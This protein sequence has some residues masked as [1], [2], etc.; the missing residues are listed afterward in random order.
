MNE[1]L[2]LFEE[3]VNAPENGAET[4]CENDYLVKGVRIEDLA[5]EKMKNRSVR[6]F[7]KGYSDIFNVRVDPSQKGYRIALGINA[8]KRKLGKMIS[9]AGTK[10]NFL[11]ETLPEIQKLLGCYADDIQLVT[12]EMTGHNEIGYG[13]CSQSWQL[14]SMKISSMAGGKE[15]ATYVPVGRKGKREGFWFYNSNRNEV[16]Y[17]GD[18]SDLLAPVIFLNMLQEAIRGQCG[19][20]GS[21]VKRLLEDKLEGLFSWN[22][23]VGELTLEEEFR[24]LLEEKGYQLDLDQM[25]YIRVPGGRLT[26]TDEV[27]GDGQ[28]RLRWLYCLYKCIRS[29]ERIPFDLCMSR[30]ECL[31][32]G[33]DGMQCCIGS[34]ASFALDEMYSVLLAGYMEFKAEESYAKKLNSSIATAYITKKNI[35]KAVIKA[36]QDS[37]FN[38]KFGYVEYDEEVNIEAAEQIAEEFSR[39]NA[40]LFHGIETKDCSM[41]I[42]KLGKHKAAGIYFPMLNC[43]C[44]DIHNPDSFVHEYYH[45]LDD[46][47]GNLS[48]QYEFHAVCGEYKD[49]LYKSLKGM[50]EKKKSQLKGTGK[51]NLSYYCRP[52]EIFARCGEMYLL[53]ELHVKSS[54]LKPSVEEMFAYPEGEELSKLIKAYFDD[55]H[56]SL[57]L[58]GQAAS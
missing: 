4:G 8:V 3:A 17:L 48:A 18:M 41:R 27:M 52:A 51:Y 29:G 2:R 39:L 33:I 46:Q 16:A 54:L 36:M 45:M 13:L 9:G 20:E 57:L 19:E 11:L 47:M 31:K 24:D 1:L 14:L 7:K 56:G 15:M 58:K 53:R 50:D 37:R 23:K 38:Q 12:G 10:E 34:Y 40:G 43:M 49:L 26:D 5:R 32:S 44:V 6:E 42:R 35:P 21:K 25:S 30:I 28:T 22:Y 55:F